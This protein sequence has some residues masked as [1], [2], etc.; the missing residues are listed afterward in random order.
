MLR[1]F[2][3]DWRKLKKLI[4]G[5]LKAQLATEIKRMNYI[6][7]YRLKENQIEKKE[8]KLLYI[9]TTQPEKITIFLQKNFPEAK[10]ISST[11]LQNSQ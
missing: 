10:E 2:P 3:P 8:E 7:S 6:Q 11:N 4:T 1:T 5:L 9:Q